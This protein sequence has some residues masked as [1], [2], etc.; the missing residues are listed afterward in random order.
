MAPHVFV[1]DLSIASIAQA[2]VAW[3]DD[4]PAARGS[5]ATTTTSTRRSAAGTT[6]GSH[7][8]L[9]RVEHRGRDCARVRCPVLAIQGEDDEYGTMEQVERIAR[10]A[11][12]RRRAAPRRLPALA[13]PRP[14]GRGARRARALRR[15]AALSGGP[16]S[17]ARSPARSRARAP[18]ASRCRAAGPAGRGGR[19]RPSGS[20]RTRRF[21]AVARIASAG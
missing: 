8:G 11:R 12:R 3:R 1:E 4:R 7:P 6:S 19:A 18:S 13:A 5:R 16:A 15:P 20:G 9:P 10:L 14:A 2:K 17:G 21:F